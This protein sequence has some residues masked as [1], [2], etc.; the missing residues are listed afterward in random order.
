M[1]RARWIQVR[2]ILLLAVFFSAG[3][4][5]PSLDA[6]VYHGA[7][8]ER[9]RS[10]AHVEPAGGCLN[11]AEH[12]SLGRTAPGSGAVGVAAG[13]PPVASVSTPA[14]RPLVTQSLCSTHRLTL[15]RPRAPPTLR[16]V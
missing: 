3:S 9:S 12:C 5:L 13:T 6:L 15:A 16:F 14:P 4:S 8:A 7:A 2:A 10:Q 11:H 1:S